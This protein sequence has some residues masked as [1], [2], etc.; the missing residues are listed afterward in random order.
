VTELEAVLAA[1]GG[2]PKA[3]VNEIVEYVN[4]QLAQ[5]RGSAGDQLLD[6]MTD[7]EVEGEKLNELELAT[8]FILL[9]SAGNDSTRAT[10]SATMLELL[11]NP[12]LQPGGKCPGCRTS[13]STASRAARVLRRR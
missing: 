2:P 6:A 9:M 12:E 5:R 10:Y 1:V 4:N 8:F 13:R 3:V 11:C 7:A